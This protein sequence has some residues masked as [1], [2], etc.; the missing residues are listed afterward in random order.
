[1]VF[2]DILIEQ[3][4]IHSRALMSHISLTHTERV[5][6]KDLYDQLIIQEW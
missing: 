2:G 6:S 5:T 1:M 4:N 3:S